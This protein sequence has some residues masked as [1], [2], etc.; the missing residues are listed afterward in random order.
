MLLITKLEGK[1]HTAIEHFL[2]F[3]KEKNILSRFIDLS[4]KGNELHFVFLKNF[5]RKLGLA[6]ERHFS[7]FLKILF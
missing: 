6:R 3:T 4:I 5:Y 2:K 7:F 1:K